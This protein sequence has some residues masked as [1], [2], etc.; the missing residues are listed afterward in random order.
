MI[1][2]KGPKPKSKY[3]NMITYLSNLPNQVYNDMYHDCPYGILQE[4][5]ITKIGVQGNK[6]IWELK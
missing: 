4:Y 2:R 3:L 1:I 6:V 5:R